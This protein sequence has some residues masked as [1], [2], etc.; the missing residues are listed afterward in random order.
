ML[1]GHQIRINGVN[2][3][4]DTPAEDYVQKKFHNAKNDWLNKAKEKFLLKD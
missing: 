3:G 2:L 1:F 4:T